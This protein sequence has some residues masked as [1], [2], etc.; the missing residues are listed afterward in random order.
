[1]VAV[2]ILAAVMTGRVSQGEA[3]EGWSWHVVLFF[4]DGIALLVGGVMLI[5]GTARR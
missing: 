4:L 5:A 1:M 3:F 2:L